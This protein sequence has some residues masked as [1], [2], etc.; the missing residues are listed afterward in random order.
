MR[1]ANEAIANQRPNQ[2]E[3][4]RRERRRKLLLPIA[5]VTAAIVAV[6]AVAVTH[7][8]LLTPQEETKVEDSSTRNQNT[9]ISQPNGL[10]GLQF[11]AAD[12]PTLLKQPYDWT[13]LDTSG[14]YYSYAVDGSTKSVLGIDVSQHQGDI[15]WEKVKAAGIQFVYLRVGYRESIGAKV[16]ADSNFKQNLSDAKAAGLKVG[17]YFYSQ[18]TTEEE[19]REEADLTLQMLDGASID[20][21]VAFDFEPTNDSSGT[22]VSDL[23]ADQMTKVAKAFCN[24]IWSSGYST[25]I[26]GN[27]ADL[28]LYN[29][30]DLAKYGFWYA[31]Y[32]SHPT[33]DLNFVLWQYT[34]EGTVDGIEGN[35]DIDLDLSAANDTISVT[36]SG[37]DAKAAPSSSGSD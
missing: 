34:D 25:I 6:V 35:V 28:S 18:A 11:A 30:S 37:E 5:L 7:P 20:Y 8:S 16:R 14:S 13:N 24:R 1:T 33:M 2:R 19:A 29:L 3:Q 26:Y 21:P 9:D 27:S 36:K 32:G 23:S 10:V 4:M 31:E 22:R 15:D 17:V 12:S